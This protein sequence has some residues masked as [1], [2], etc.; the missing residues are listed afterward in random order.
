MEH[1]ALRSAM[2]IY[3]NGRTLSCLVC[4]KSSA[5]CAALTHPLQRIISYDELLAKYARKANCDQY[6]SPDIYTCPHCGHDRLTIEA[7]YGHFCAVHQQ[8]ADGPVESTEVR[9]PVC[10]C[11]RL[12]GSASFVTNGEGLGGHLVARHCFT[13][14]RQYSDERDL[15]S[16]F[17]RDN[18]FELLR[19]M[20]IFLS[21]GTLPSECQTNG[22]PANIKEVTL[23]CP[24]CLELID[25]N[26]SKRL[27]PCSHQF[28]GE[29]INR[30]LA[31]KRC[32]PVCRSE[33]A[34]E[35]S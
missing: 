16:Q 26:R 13:T 14:D 6:D 23:V 3:L 8:T 5:S 1:Q 2:S 12:D 7:L 35:S 32:C 28:H 10:V 27:P 30:W 4:P 18:E 25:D 29:C 24:I 15:R 31:E 33:C 22:T 9:C 20:A 34:A 11:F 17:C 21:P 19:F